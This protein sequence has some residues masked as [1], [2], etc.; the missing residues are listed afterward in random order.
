MIADFGAG[1][2]NK[3]CISGKKNSK[4]KLRTFREEGRNRNQG[5]NGIGL[6]T[7]RRMRPKGRARAVAGT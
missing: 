2:I 7:L 5:R 1:R 4:L 6:P 3:N